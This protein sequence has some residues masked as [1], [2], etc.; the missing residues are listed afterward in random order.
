MQDVDGSPGDPRAHHVPGVGPCVGSFEGRVGRVTLG[1]EPGWV[2]SGGR[3]RNPDGTRD[4]G[5]GVLDPR[6][7]VRRSQG[8][9]LLDSDVEGSSGVPDTLKDSV[10]IRRYGPTREQGTV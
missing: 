5:W 2:R 7:V 8:R 10:G 9:F 1:P 4:A 6:G 3:S